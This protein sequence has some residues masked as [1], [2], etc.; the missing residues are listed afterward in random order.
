[1]MRQGEKVKMSG[2]DSEETS[3][4]SLPIRLLL[5]D[6][7]TLFCQGLK[8]VLELQSD[9][10]VVGIVDNGEAALQQ[11]TKLKPNLVLMDLGLPVMDGR[12][13]TREICQQFPE[14]KVLVLSMFDDERY[15]SDSIRS[16]AKGY[17]LKDTPVEELIQSIR[18]AHRGYTQLSP[19]LMEKLLTGTL[20]SNNRPETDF[21][22][23]DLTALTLREREVLRLIARGSTNREIA[24]QL[25][26]TEGTVKTHV[27]NLFNRLNR[28]NRTQL[29]IF[30]NLAFK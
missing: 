20:D 29:A 11:V 1:M 26:I 2:N 8:T 19:G 3:D 5:V 17:L 28:R 9:L 27:T 12:E 15:I 6:S 4:R 14:V 13:A 22:S 30:A 23:P 10:Q 25:Y 7:Q 21:F 24:E 18:L 16:G